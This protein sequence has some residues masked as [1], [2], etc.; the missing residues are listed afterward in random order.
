MLNEESFFSE[1]FKRIPKELINKIKNKRVGIAGAGGLGSNIAVALVRSGI[2][3]LLI[4]DF[5]KVEYSNLNRQYYFYK[6]IGLYKVDALEEQ[7]KNINPYINLEKHSVYLNEDNFDIFKDCEVIVEAFDKAE[8]K[9]K[10]VDYAVRNKK[11]I[12]SGIGMAGDYSANIIN[13]KR[14]G[15][16]LYISGDFINEANEKNGLLASRVAIVANHQANMVLRILQNK[17]EV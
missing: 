13:T 5:D 7:L 2:K 17:Y 9:E 8:S 4:I 15:K 11:Y 6:H 3:N 10:I 14:V 1:A 12:V 16:Y